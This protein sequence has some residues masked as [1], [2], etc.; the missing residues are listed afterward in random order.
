MDY[1]IFLIEDLKS[2]RKKIMPT[3]SL[4]T[5]LIRSCCRESLEGYVNTI[6]S[7][8]PQSYKIN[9][10]LYYSAFLNG[11]YDDY[12][13]MK[14]KSSNSINNLEINVDLTLQERISFLY[15]RKATF[16]PVNNNTNETNYTKN[17]HYLVNSSIFIPFE[18]CTN[19]MKKNVDNKENSK[20]FYTQSTPNFNFNK[21]KKL[22]YVDIISGFNRSTDANYSVCKNCYF[23][24]NPKLYIIF[25]NQINMDNVQIINLISPL[26]LLNDIDNIIKNNGEKY[27]FISD[28]HNHPQNKEI[29][30]N[31]LFYFQLLNLPTIVM[32]LQPDFIKLRTKVEEMTSDM[33]K[34]KKSSEKVLTHQSF[35]L[36]TITDRNSIDSQEEY[37]DYTYNTKYNAYEKNLH[38]KMYCLYS[39]IILA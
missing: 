22:N 24:I 39:I 19:C 34:L 7:L 37:L 16:H 13:Q 5:K 31:I 38:H 36:K 29:F 9:N 20:N 10:P 26:K 14:D 2:E 23:K 17:V 25:E 18:F 27:F 12:S 1:A 35:I 4:Y 28:Y 8:M 6:F 3:R 15:K 30:W 33:L 21:V 11:L 32:T